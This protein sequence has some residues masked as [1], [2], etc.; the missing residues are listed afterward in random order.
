MG[1][2]SLSARPLCRGPESAAETIMAQEKDDLQGIG[3]KDHESHDH[4]APTKSSDSKPYH[5]E[6]EISILGILIVLA[7]YKK[8]ILGL[9]FLAAILAAGITLLMPIWY[10]GTVKTRARS[11]S[12]QSR[13]LQLFFGCL[14][15]R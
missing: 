1:A 9:P 14:A 6:E 15:G 10:T 11:D 5:N 2:D 4:R 7:K 3:T 13:R 12:E 8:L